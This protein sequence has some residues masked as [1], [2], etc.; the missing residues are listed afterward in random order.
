[1]YNCEISGE[2]IEVFRIRYETNRMNEQ[3]EGILSFNLERVGQEW[4]VTLD[5]VGGGKEKLR[6]REGKHWY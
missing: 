2:T 3:I 5:L 4:I 6:S 1:M